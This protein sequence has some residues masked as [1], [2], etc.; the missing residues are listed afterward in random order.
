MNKILKSRISTYDAL[1]S[2]LSSLSDDHLKKLIDSAAPLGKSIGGTSLLLTMDNKPIFIKKIKLADFEKQPQNYGSTRNYFALPLYYQYGVGSAGFGA[3]RELAVHTM[4]TNWVLTGECINFPLMYHHR[5]LP[6][7]NCVTT[8]EE[9]KKIEQDVAYWEGSSAIRSRLLSNEEA[10]TDI[11]LFLE[12]F[13]SNLH[14]W[15]TKQLNKDADVIQSACSMIEDELKKTI[16]FMQSKDLVHMDAHFWNILTDGNRLYFTDFGLA[17][18]PKFELSDTEIEF[19]NQHKNYDNYSSVTYFI[20]I[21]ITGLYGQNDWIEKLKECITKIDMLPDEL[22]VVVKRYSSIAIIMDEFYKKMQS[23]SK[24]TLL[25]VDQ[26]N[27]L[28]VEAGRP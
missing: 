24:T 9:L 4:T 26:L 12:Y 10:V 8:E 16:A 6:S 3:W 14:S 1:S 7:S 22:D 28:L 15:L 20:Y 23:V 13:P 19:L 27:K 11:V 21:I 5:I 18:S 2:Q 25:P 17:L